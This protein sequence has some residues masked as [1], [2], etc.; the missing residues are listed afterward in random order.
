[1]AVG[2]RDFTR[3]GIDAVDLAQQHPRI[4]LAVEDAAYRPGHVGGVEAG[5]GH[6]VEQGLEQVEVAAVDHGDVDR[7]LG[8][9]ARRAEAAEAGADD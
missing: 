9:G 7:S 2:E 1:M 3:G 4:G 5:G 8:Q 6:L